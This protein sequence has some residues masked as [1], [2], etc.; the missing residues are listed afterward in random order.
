MEETT[1]DL[2]AYLGTALGTL[3]LAAALAWSG[4]QF[5]RQMRELWV[6]L[7]G[8]RE[9]IEQAVDQPT[10]PVIQRLAQLMALPPD[11]LVAFSSAFL[12]ALADG[13]DHTTGI[14]MEENGV[15]QDS[16]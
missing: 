2:W 16:T 12:R 14:E 5:A 7:R 4:K 10:D 11:V 9:L 6:V 3:L 15:H 8:H 1:L 13:L